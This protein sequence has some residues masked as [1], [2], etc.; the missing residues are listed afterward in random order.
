MRTDT[1][2]LPIRFQEA[3]NQAAL[4]EHQKTSIGTYGEKSVHATLKR[5]FQ[6]DTHFHEQPVAGYI[7]DICFGDEIYEIQTAHFYSLRKKLDAFLKEYQVTVVYPIPYMK[8]ICW[9][10]PDTGEVK[11]RRRSPKK[12]R[13]QHIFPEIYRLRAY[14][15][16]PNL[17]FC[18]MLLDMEE[19]RLLDGHGAERKKHSTKYDRIPTR[20]EQELWLRQPSD[21]RQLLPEGLPEEFTA[22]EFAKAA[23]IPLKTAQT[24]LLLLTELGIVN[25]IG[26]AERS[27]LY[28]TAL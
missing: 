14:L 1:T 9:T 12:G 20:L 18:I 15:R 27:Y 22:R 2:S 25:R 7:A 11:E 24:G 17:R 3:C 6:P 10:D 28:C 26:K 21:Y 19:C 8:W 4:Q 5:Y 23:R 16:H 13:L